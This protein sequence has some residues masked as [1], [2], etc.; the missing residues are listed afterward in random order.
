MY[1]SIKYTVI[2]TA[3]CGDFSTEM[4]FTAMGKCVIIK[5]REEVSPVERL[6]HLIAPYR[7]V[8]LI[9][10]CKNAGKTTVLNQIIR[11]ETQNATKLALTS[12]GRDGESKD[13][14]TGTAK[15]GIY[16][17]EGTLIAT[18][19][20]MALRFC[21]VTKEILDTT[22]MSTPL[23]RVVLLRAMSDGNVQLAGPSMTGQLAQLRERFFA[24][25]ADKVLIDGALSRKSLCGR[26]VSEATILCTG[27]S[28]HKNL[29]KVV[30]DTAYYCRI[31][32]LPETADPAIRALSDS[33]DRGI[34]VLTPDGSVPLTQTLEETLRKQA[35]KAVFFGGALTDLAVKP[36]LMSSIPL[37]N[38]QFVVRDSSKI[39]LKADSF[40]RLLRR[41]VRLQVIDSVNLVALTVNPFSAYGFH[42]DGR[43]LKERM[44]Q[45]VQL[46]VFD[47]MEGGLTWN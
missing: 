31:L 40:E 21:D 38:L 26:H 13:L 1:N 8:S 12:I 33:E 25:G 7:S 22:D 44:A 2:T 39:L 3:V 46:P 41:G 30:E 37:Q 47:V 34:T 11:E 4:T 35:A 27:A 17:P 18:A 23:G 28:Y 36:L 24:L 19:D 6:S 9:G 14:V 10:M 20:Q 15:P 32:T 45:A 43:E 16:V 5:S 42:F 29:Q